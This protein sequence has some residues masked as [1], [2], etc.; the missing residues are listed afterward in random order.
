MSDKPEYGEKCDHASCHCK[1]QPHLGVVVGEEV[2]CS[3]GCADG[4][5]CEHEHCACSS[6]DSR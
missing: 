1:T 6:A 5:G 4:N 2:Y 3:Q